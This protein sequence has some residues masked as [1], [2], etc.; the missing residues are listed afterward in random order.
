MS[1]GYV[2]VRRIVA[3]FP[4]THG[5][6]YVVF[7]G[8]LRLIDWGVKRIP[9]KDHRENLR[10]VDAF[11]DWFE[12]DAVILENVAGEGSWKGKRVAALIRAIGRRASRRHICVEAY[13]RSLVR[14]AF[15]LVCAKT[16]SEIAEVVANDYE[17]L[18]PLLPRK[19]K[20]W[21]AEDPRMG[22]FDA[23]SLALTSYHFEHLGP[24][25]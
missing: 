22:V 16:K 10:K 21:M 5:F 8:P 20:L 17:Q 12:P 24:Q 4:N 13:S 11:L 23:A 3:L 2:K 9:S 1:H 19:R 15:S 6:G 18:R 7:E 25:H 14:Q